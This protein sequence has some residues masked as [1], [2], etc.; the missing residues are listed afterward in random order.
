[1]D[2]N[3]IIILLTCLFGSMVISAIALRL[4]FKNRELKIVVEQKSEALNHM[5]KETEKLAEDKNMY[6]E[7]CKEIE[8]AVEKG[9]GIKIRN[10]VTEVIVDF[11]KLEMVLIYAGISKLLK[12]TD[13]PEDAR[14]YVDLLEKIQG[15]LDDMK[16]EEE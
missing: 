12:E 7:R 4:H 9:G 14:H 6:Q 10:E 1:M 2:F 11:K 5:Y 13:N 15:F 3:S 8:D 16:E